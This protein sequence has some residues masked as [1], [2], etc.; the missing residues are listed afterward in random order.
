MLVLTIPGL[1]HYDEQRNEFIVQEDVV[2]ELEHSLVSLS[3]WESSWEKPFLSLTPKTDEETLDYVKAMTLTSNVDPEVYSRLTPENFAEINSYLQAKMTATWFAEKEPG[4]S[5]EIVTAEVIYYWMISLNI[6]MECQHWHISRLMTLVSV[7]NEKNAP[8]K[9][10]SQASLA[11][12][13]RRLNAERRA[14]LG[15]TG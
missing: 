9:K 11:E 14:K 10:M 4:R 13:N 8:K 1:D 15:T 2:L 5:R 6:P 7:F 12:R 3:K